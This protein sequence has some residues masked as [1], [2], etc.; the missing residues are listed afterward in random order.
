M[1]N[2][3][4]RAVVSLLVLF[5]FPGTGTGAPFAY[6][7]NLEDN[8]VSVINTAPYEVRTVQVGTRP[9]GVAVHPDGS[10]VYVTNNG[11]NTEK[12]QD[13]CRIDCS[14]EIL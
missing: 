11:D 12:F 1:R 3:T 14:I 9:K 8:T 4:R 13:R 5:F 2:L 6:V 7:T 10:R